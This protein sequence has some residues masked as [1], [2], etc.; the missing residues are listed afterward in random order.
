MHGY[1]PWKI[2]WSFGFYTSH[3]V[4]FFLSNLTN[5]KK[6]K[7]N[8]NFLSSDLDF[9]Y[10]M[11]VNNRLSGIATKKTKFLESLVKVDFPQR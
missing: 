7:Y 6:G 3:S 10:K 9:F 1:E 2:K 8:L 4:G 11:I 5:I